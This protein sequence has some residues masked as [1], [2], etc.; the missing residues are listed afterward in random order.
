MLG[1]KAE[2]EKELAGLIKL[3]SLD[4][5][6]YHT[7]GLLLRHRYRAGTFSNDFATWAA[8]QV[9][10]RVLGERLAVLDPLS[11]DTLVDLRDEIVSV[12]DSHLKSI[13]VVP[14]V[15]YGEPFNFIQSRIVAVPAGTVAYTLEEFRQAVSEVDDRTLYYHTLDARIQR[16][17]RQND[18]SSWLRDRLSLR[19][20]AARIEVLNPFTGGLEQVRTQMLA[21]CDQVLSQGRDL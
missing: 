12:I 18:F 5:I 7:C 8:V 2:T 11:F 14:R 15:V 9:G 20:L 10:D 13:A 3:V 6:Y 4:S 1:L 21:Y 16:K 17:H 19:A